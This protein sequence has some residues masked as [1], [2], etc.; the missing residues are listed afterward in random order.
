MTPTALNAV[1]LLISISYS[2]YGMADVDNYQ[3]I[4]NVRLKYATYFTGMVNAV[5]QSDEIGNHILRDINSQVQ[6]KTRL[7]FNDALEDRAT[8]V[9]VEAELKKCWQHIKRYGAFAK[10]IRKYDTHIAK[11]KSKHHTGQNG[12]SM[13]EGGQEI[14]TMLRGLRDNLVLHQTDDWPQEKAWK[15]LLFR[16]NVLFAKA[17]FEDED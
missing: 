8:K 10:T 6:N 3:L 15:W 16:L 7:E 17:K 13:S 12:E 5:I 2:V 1:F 4:A 11:I 14:M 9:I